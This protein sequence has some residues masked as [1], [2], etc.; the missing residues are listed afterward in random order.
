MPSQTD[1]KSRLMSTEGSSISTPGNRACLSQFA[2]KVHNEAI[3][4]DGHCD[5][6][7]PVADGKMRLHDHPEVPPVES[8]QPPLGWQR[9]AEAEL[10]AFSAHTDYFQTMS[11]YDIPR[12]LAGGV[13]VQACAVYIEERH[14]DRALER[15]LDMIFWLHREVAEDSRFELARG[16]EDIL[17]VKAQGRTSALLTFEGFEPLGANLQLLD[18]FYELGLR[19]ASL[20]HSRRNAFADGLQRGV[21]TGGLSGLGRAAIKR[22]N[23]LGIVIDLAHLNQPGCWEAL[24]RSERPVVW[25]H[26]PPRRYFPA[27]PEMSPLYGDLVQPRARELLDELAKNG[28]VMGVIAFGQPTFDDFLDDIDYL[29]AAIGV[30]HVGIGTD[31]FGREQA[32]VGFQSIDDMPRLTSGLLDRGYAESDVKKILGANFLRVFDQVWSHR[33]S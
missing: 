3:V 8:W 31:F 15:A 22:M 23:E 7:I 5:I 28:G 18:V 24:G 14:L 21:T 4:I 26:T 12:F 25:S 29:V 10:Y 33:L 19:M 30:D 1:G 2:Q 17:R 13:T 11:Q 16:V 9:S 6:L 20:T 27:N 32:P